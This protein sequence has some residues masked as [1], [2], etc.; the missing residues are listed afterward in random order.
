MHFKTIKFL[1]LSLATLAILPVLAAAQPKEGD[2]EIGLAA[3]YYHP[4]GTGRGLFN[5]DAAYGFFPSDE[6]E[7]GLR[8][9]F[10]YS[11]SA[12]VKDVWNAVTAPFAL[13]HFSDLGWAGDNALVPYLGGF[14]GAVWNEDDFTGTMGP[15]AGLKLYLSETTFLNA[16][17]RYEWFFE[18]IG[19]ANETQD[20]NHV[21]LIGIGYNWQ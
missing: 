6:L 15:D 18:E 7:I 20:A 2:Q 19:E 17:Y 4:L 16:G 21:A 3:S 1:V 8:Q 12:E 11:Q 9:S 14:I 5:F 13:Y 10:T